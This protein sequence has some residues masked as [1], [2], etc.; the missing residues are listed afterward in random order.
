MQLHSY[1]STLSDPYPVSPNYLDHALPLHTLQDQLSYFFPDG[2]KRAHPF[3]DIRKPDYL[4]RQLRFPQLLKPLMCQSSIVILCT[5]L[6][7]QFLYD[8]QHFPDP[9]R[10]FRFLIH[11]HHQNCLTSKALE[12]PIQPVK[13]ITA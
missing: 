12:N 13:F 1:H 7:L 6:S 5:L 10:Q 11:L 8:G 9:L 3:I 4:V 2:E